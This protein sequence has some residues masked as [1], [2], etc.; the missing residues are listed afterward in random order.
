MDGLMSEGHGLVPR[1]ETRDK[2]ARSQHAAVMSGWRATALCQ[3]LLHSHFSSERAAY[4]SALA[5]Y[6]RTLA[7]DGI[8]PC[9]LD[10]PF[11]TVFPAYLKHR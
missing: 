1:T 10:L 9:L 8:T 3:N 2:L 6:A 5:G 7:G 11:G 4:S